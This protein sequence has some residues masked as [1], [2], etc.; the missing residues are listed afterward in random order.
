MTSI[1][2]TNTGTRVMFDVLLSDLPDAVRIDA[3]SSD[4]VPVDVSYRADAPFAV[5]ACK[6]LAYEYQPAGSPPAETRGSDR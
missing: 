6:E 2:E 5:D 1:D 3:A 4:E